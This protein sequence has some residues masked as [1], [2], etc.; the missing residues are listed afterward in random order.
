MLSLNNIKI[1]DYVYDLHNKLRN[2]TDEICLTIVE[3]Q[4]SYYLSYKFKNLFIENIKNIENNNYKKFIEN[5]IILIENKNSDILCDKFENLYVENLDCK[6]FIE[7]S[8]KDIFEKEKNR[9][10]YV[11]NGKIFDIENFS[12]KI[13][14][15]NKEIDLNFEIN[16][17]DLFTYEIINISCNQDFIKEYDKKLQIKNSKFNFINYKMS[18]E[19]HEDSCSARDK[20]SNK[21]FKILNS[22]N[23]DLIELDIQEIKTIK[24]ISI[25]AT[26]NSLENSIK[27]LKQS[28]KERYNI[29]DIDVS[30]IDTYADDDYRDSELYGDDYD[31]YELSAIVELEPKEKKYKQKH[32]FKD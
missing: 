29:E 4:D 10:K 20:F 22:K 21:A 28:I 18:Y 19:L 8:L 5:F 3:N 2:I 17:I 6:K 25:M 30:V 31:R 1:N 26:K 32:I 12:N 23:F 9:D 16:N 24:K 7:K 15:E 13:K 27:L 11:K 14:L